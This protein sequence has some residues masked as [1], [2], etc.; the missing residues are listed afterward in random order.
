M[1]WYEI[2][3]TPE[4]KRDYV[5]GGRILL[6]WDERPKK[7]IVQQMQD[8]GS[9]ILQRVVFRP[10]KSAV[11]T[12]GTIAIMAPHLLSIEDRLDVEQRFPKGPVAPTPF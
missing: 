7:I 6:V 8:D 2:R 3:I 9:I 10:D 5:R 11:E 4:E 1:A 12:R